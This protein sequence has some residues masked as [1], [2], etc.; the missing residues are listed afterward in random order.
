ML[1]QTSFTHYYLSLSPLP[2]SFPPS[3]SPSLPLLLSLSHALTCFK[4][5]PNAPLNFNLNPDPNELSILT[6]SWNSPIGT[7]ENVPINYTISISGPRVNRND[8]VTSTTYQ[9]TDA[10]DQTCEEHTFTVFA[11]NPAG[12][13]AVISMEQTIPICKA[14]FRCLCQY[15]ACFMLSLKSLHCMSKVH[16]IKCT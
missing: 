13:G 4:G 1:F 8:T 16:Q 9:F 11:T 14:A 15:F 12:R 10:E 2:S 3:L 6:L 7:F 5:A